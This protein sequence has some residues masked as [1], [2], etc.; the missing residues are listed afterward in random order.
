[1]N[2]ERFRVRDIP[3]DIGDDIR[4]SLAARFVEIGFLRLAQDGSQRSHT[5]AG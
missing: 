2:A 3:G 5:A 4:L 1:V